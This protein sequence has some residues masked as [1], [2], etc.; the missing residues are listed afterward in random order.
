MVHSGY[1]PLKLNAWMGEQILQKLELIMWPLI[2][3]G[4]GT[5]VCVCVCVC[6]CCVY[7]VCVIPLSLSSCRD[8]N[9]SLSRS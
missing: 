7:V 9:Y 5:S 2:I 8:I 1:H 4:F 3:N 6:V